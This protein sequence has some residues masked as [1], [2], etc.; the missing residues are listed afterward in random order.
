MRILNYNYNNINNIDIGNVKKYRYKQIFSWLHKNLVKEFDDMINIPNDIKKILKAK[1]IIETAI[2]DEVF[3]SKIDGTIK[4]VF[5]L[6]DGNYVEGIIL[7]YKYGNTL[8]ISSQIGCSMG[9]TFCASTKGGLVRNLDQS[10]M[11]SML[12]SAHRLINDRIN[13][14]VFM[15]IGEPLDNYNNVL[16]FIK[17]ISDT[18]SYNISKRNITISTC[19]IVDKIYKL[20]KENMPLTLAISL[21]S[22]YQE[23]RKEIMP[24]SNKHSL[25][26]LIKAAKFYQD[27][28]GRRVSVEY[29]LID[30]ENSS[31]K[32][33]KDLAM[34]LKDSFFH[35]NLIAVNKIKESDN[36]PP[37]RKQILDFKKVLEYDLIHVTIRRELGSDISGSCGQLRSKIINKF[38]RKE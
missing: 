26:E 13:N 2:I 23:K 28:T 18:N 3:T 12:Y 37:S 7:K 38:K 31:K 19:G 25:D 5:R 29:A 17:T 20:A 36:S 4:I 32:D 15:G 6:L 35:V 27:K 9:C 21:H 8:C 1:Y 30:G 11:I 24:I 33:A 10:E 14:I 22:P 16:E 34:L